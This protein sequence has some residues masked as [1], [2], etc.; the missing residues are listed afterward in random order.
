MRSRRTAIIIVGLALAAGAAEAEES[1]SCYGAMTPASIVLPD[2][3]VHAQGE[4][5]VCMTRRLSPVE[6]INVISVNGDAIGAFRGGDG[7]IER[8]LDP[9]QPEFVFLKRPDAS[10]Q[11]FGFI[12]SDRHG[13]R[14]H[15]L[16][17]RARLDDVTLVAVDMGGLSEG[18]SDAT[19]RRARRS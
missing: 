5:R 2:G 19:H 14:L 13:A 12:T 17:R 7:A 4:L 15:N 3:S 6:W 1:G 9:H 18:S 10:L 16:L 11:L 8:G